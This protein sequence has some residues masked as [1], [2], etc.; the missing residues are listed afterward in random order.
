MLFRSNVIRNYTPKEMS[1]FLNQSICTTVCKKQ[2]P[3]SECTA[4]RPC[5]NVIEDWLHE[6]SIGT[7]MLNRRYDN[8]DYDSIV[9]AIQELESVSHLITSEDIKS[10]IKASHKLLPKEALDIENIYDDTKDYVYTT[11]KCPTCSVFNIE[12][13]GFFTTTICPSCGQVIDWNNWFHIYMK[14]E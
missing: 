4:K 2:S 3:L 10:L 8:V 9:T 12:N 1:I 13:V 5:A 6:S 7:L 11:F 14:R